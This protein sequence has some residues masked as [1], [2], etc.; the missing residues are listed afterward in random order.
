MRTFYS[1]VFL[2][3][4]LGSLNSNACVEEIKHKFYTCSSDKFSAS[5]IPPH[6]DDVTVWV[7]KK[8]NIKILEDDIAKEQFLN[9]KWQGINIFHQQMQ[10]NLLNALKQY[11]LNGIRIKRLVLIGHQVN[12]DFGMGISGL[13]D[14]TDFDF[15]N[16]DSFH[17]PFIPQEQ[18][19][20]FLFNKNQYLEVDALQ[21]NAEVFVYSCKFGK[22]LIGAAMVKLLG[23]ILLGKRG[24]KIVAPKGDFNVIARSDFMRSH[25]LNLHYSYSLKG[26]TTYTINKNISYFS[27]RLPYRLDEIY[28]T[29]SQ[30]I[31][32]HQW[33][34]PYNS[35]LVEARALLEIQP[36]NL[37]DLAA[38]YF[39][40]RNSLKDEPSGLVNL[41]KT[42]LRFHWYSF[43]ELN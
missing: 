33:A 34:Y 3:L 19:S 29:L 16:V 14:F 11:S 21:E 8:G 27:P 41:Q 26:W 35:N 24:G 5:Q 42:L 15:G 36:R 9:S 2:F 39:K 43:T 12:D 23:D 20:Y 6:S 22:G 30:I 25:N 18:R 32:S 31:Q 7:Y 17:R 37:S 38:A 4:S 40:L 10:G 1:L 28:K 13:V